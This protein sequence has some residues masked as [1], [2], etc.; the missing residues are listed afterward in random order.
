MLLKN[1][2]LDRILIYVSLMGLS[3]KT[4]ND[5]MEYAI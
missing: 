3:R 5:D 4:S 1:A 2:D